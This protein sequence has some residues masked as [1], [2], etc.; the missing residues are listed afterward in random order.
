MD[1]ENAIRGNLDLKEA[2]FGDYVRAV[3]GPVGGW[4]QTLDPDR[5]GGLGP[6]GIVM[7]CS[8]L[9]V[10]EM[11][12]EGERALE[13]AAVGN[14]FVEGS[15]FSAQ[16]DRITYVEVKDLLILESD[17]RNLVTLKQQRQ[18]GT[19]P[20]LF[21]CHKMKYGLRSGLVDVDGAVNLQYNQIGSPGNIPERASGEADG[22][23]GSSCGSCS[24]VVAKR[25]VIAALAPT[26]YRPR[27][28]CPAGI[29]DNGPAICM[30]QSR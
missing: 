13:I 1:F 28:G 7:T 14:T 4:D 18:A 8:R 15:Q 3:Y 5:R 21:Q 6:D 9:K 19:E 17:G 22:A 27:P 20:A 25:I 10:V 2:E 24:R 26:S 16:A 11:G 29:P 30:P 12:G 23:I